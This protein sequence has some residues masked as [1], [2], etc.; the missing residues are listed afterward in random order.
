MKL[1]LNV[2]YQPLNIPVSYGTFSASLTNT[3]NQLIPAEF[4][5]P[6][7]FLHHQEAIGLNSLI[8]S[9][10][11]A[12]MQALSAAAHPFIYSPRINNFGVL[13]LTVRAIH[14]K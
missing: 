6:P 9:K 13:V 10:A 14:N 2:I 4:L 7:I 5:P 1:L 11:G 12:T 3:C 8:G